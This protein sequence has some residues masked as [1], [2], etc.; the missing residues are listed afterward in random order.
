VTKQYATSPPD[1]FRRQCA[2]KPCLADSCFTHDYRNVPSAVH[3]VLEQPSQ[4]LQLGLAAEQRRFL[5]GHIR[6]A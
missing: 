2:Q 1:R 5:A 3:S 6:A 4:P